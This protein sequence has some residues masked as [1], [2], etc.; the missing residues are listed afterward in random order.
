MHICIIYFFLDSGLPTLYQIVTYR[1]AL[2]IL[3]VCN[4]ESEDYNPES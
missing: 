2:S 3:G 4:N 1:Y